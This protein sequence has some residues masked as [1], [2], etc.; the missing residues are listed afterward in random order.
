MHPTRAFHVPTHTHVSPNASAPTPRRRPS[1]RSC[2]RGRR[3]IYHTIT[4]PSS[5]SSA[6]LTG[7]R[8]SN[9]SPGASSPSARAE[10][11]GL[12]PPAGPCVPAACGAL[13]QPPLVALLTPYTFTSSISK[14]HYPTRSRLA[15]SPD[16]SRALDARALCSALPAGAP[17][18]Q[19]FI[20]PPRCAQRGR[21][22]RCQAHHCHQRGACRLHAFAPPPGTLPNNDNLTSTPSD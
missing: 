21:R 17:V 10:K 19:G 15:R 6:S 12:G 9:G 4:H 16:R 22:S 5:S 8:R 7:V 14:C 3:S 18:L 20:R 1:P 13:H 2:S 11:G